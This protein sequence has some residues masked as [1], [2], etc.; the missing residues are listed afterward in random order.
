MAKKLII[1]RICHHSGHFEFVFSLALL[2]KI[3]IEDIFLMYDSYSVYQS[4]RNNHFLNH[5]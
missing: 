4:V 5:I 3:D 1:A 2:L